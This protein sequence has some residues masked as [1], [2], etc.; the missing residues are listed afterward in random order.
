MIWLRDTEASTLAALKKLGFELSGSTRNA[1]LVIGRVDA[2][3]LER[4][5]AIASVRWVAPAP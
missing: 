3:E 2:A 5:A 1:K 4:I